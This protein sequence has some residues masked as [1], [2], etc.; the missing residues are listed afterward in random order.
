MKEVKILV[1]CLCGGHHYFQLTKWGEAD[2]SVALV[3][4]PTGLWNV[5]T[6]WWHH[7]DPWIA[8]AL[9]TPE[10]IQELKREITKL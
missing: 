2:Y 9:L 10:N 1:E 5:L 4:R 8:E 6:D 7:R 3:G